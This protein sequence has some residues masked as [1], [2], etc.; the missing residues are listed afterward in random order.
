MLEGGV[1]SQSQ[2]RYCGHQVI[3]IDTVWK[4]SRLSH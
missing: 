2:E 3:G 4:K 1:V